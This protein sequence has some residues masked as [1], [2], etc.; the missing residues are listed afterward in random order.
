[1]LKP[2]RLEVIRIAVCSNHFLGIDRSVVFLFEKLSLRVRLCSSPMDPLQ[3]VEFQGVRDYAVRRVFHQDRGNVNSRRRS[4]RIDEL[5][6]AGW[7]GV[8]PHM[9]GPHSLANLLK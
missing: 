3:G 8:F 1:M 2:F 4:D 6:E 7:Q 5:F 9:A